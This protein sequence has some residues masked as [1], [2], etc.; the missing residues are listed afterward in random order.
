MVT[1]YTPES[2]KPAEVEPA[3]GPD[4]DVL[5]LLKAHSVG[6]ESPFRLF[7]IIPDAEL[8]TGFFVDAGKPNE[9]D[10]LTDNHVMRSDTGTVIMPDGSTH[11][12]QVVARDLPHDMALVQVDGVTNPQVTCKPLPLAPTDEPNA[13]N[14]TAIKIERAKLPGFLEFLG[15]AGPPGRV[16]TIAKSW[17]GNSLGLISR[18]NTPMVGLRGESMNRAFQIF[19]MRGERGESGGAIVN[20]AGLVT[21]QVEAGWNTNTLGTSISDVRA[22]LD[23]QKQQKQ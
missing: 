6:I 9:C 7:G 22:F 4:V 11:P 13:E 5:A 16:E 15:I 2:R 18:A 21:S 10:V 8:G 23:K 19:A 3:K 14:F 17:T 1:D 12:A 20:A